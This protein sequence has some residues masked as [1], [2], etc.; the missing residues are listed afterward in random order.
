MPKARSLPRST[1]ALSWT[2]GDVEA[3]DALSAFEAEDEGAGS[4]VP[5]TKSFDPASLDG[6]AVVRVEMSPNALQQFGLSSTRGNG[7][8]LADMVVASDGTP[9][10]IRLVAK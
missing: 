3:S 5:L 1:P 9:Q 2:L 7:N 8:V 10:A 6:G 4:F